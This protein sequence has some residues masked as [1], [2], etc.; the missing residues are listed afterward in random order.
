MTPRAVTAA[1]GA[2]TFGQPL[3]FAGPLTVGAAVELFL[4][5][6]RRVGRQPE[7]VRHT[8]L[9]LRPF[10]A[11][12]GFEALLSDVTLRGVE[13]GFFPAW[14]ESFERRH[15]HSPSIS[16]VR[17]LRL[18]LRGLFRF[19]DTYGLLV[20]AAGIELRNPLRSL[21]VPGSATPNIATVSTESEARILAA[22]HTPRQRIIVPFLRW[23]GL[24][25]SEAAAT[26][27]E[28][29]DLSQLEIRVRVSKTARGIRTIPLLPVLEEPVRAWRAYCQRYGLHQPGATFLV[30]RHGTPM[31]SRHIWWTVRTV[32]ARANVTAI[33]G[34]TVT[35]HTLRRT[36]AT[37]LLNRGVRLEVVSR[38]LGHSTTAVTEKFY[39]HLSD[40]RLR[41]E[42]EAAF[43]A[44]PYPGVQHETSQARSL[45]RAELAAHLRELAQTLE[46]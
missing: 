12:A 35:P 13:L 15:G 3:S 33:G 22:A 31:Q 18:A 19:A 34:H 27:D 39:A 36:Y 20:D 42:L 7:T 16:Y 29:V 38:L 5:H 32:A 24:R 17:S 21:E 28:D 23:T 2:G 26:L 11:W 4:A 8:A 44:S 9:V 14:S 25:V 1:N 43:I 6:Q 45:D 40:A 41:A 10:V 30:T 37:D 46:S